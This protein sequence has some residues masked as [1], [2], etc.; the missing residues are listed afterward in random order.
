MV[1]ALPVRP[2]ALIAIFCMPISQT[3]LCTSAD[4]NGTSIVSIPGSHVISP[5]LSYSVPD[6]EYVYSVQWGIFHAGTSVV[7]LQNAKNS[8]RIS[9]TADSAGMAD[10][11]FKVH[12][13]FFAD[14]NPRSFCTS[15]VTKHNIEGS[16]RR[17]FSISLDYAH[18]KGQ[19]DA[20]D[21][22]TS[23][24]KHSEFDIPP[25]VTDL[26]SGFF[27]VGSLPLAPGYMQVFPVNDNSKMTDARLQVETREHVKEPAGEFETL[28]VKVEPI[29]GA[30]KGKGTLWVWFTDDPRH[31]PVQ[32]K[33]KLGFATFLF[34]LQRISPPSAAK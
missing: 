29:S 20:R 13:Q 32:M 30:L 28:R 4:S 25:C 17:D 3:A 2:L 12:D 23:E 10:K 24:V 5:P 18:G 11:F 19:L 8:L 6:A 22:K 7:R 34:Q 26:I 27:Y 9:A 15:Q 21:L 31:A 1:P 33:S 14:V 16:R